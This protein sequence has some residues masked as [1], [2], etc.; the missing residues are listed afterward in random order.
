MLWGTPQPETSQDDWHE[1][2]RLC[3]PASADFILDVPH[4]YGFSPTQYFAAQ[5]MKTT[6]PSKPEIDS[7]LNHF[8]I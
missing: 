3:D 1:Y 4:Y 8:L 5:W 7:A 2:K 6:P